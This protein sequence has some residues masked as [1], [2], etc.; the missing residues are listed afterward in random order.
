MAKDI[1]NEIIQK[2]KENFQKMKNLLKK[3]I[4]KYQEGQD[5]LYGVQKLSN[6]IRVRS[7]KAIALLRRDNIK[8]SQKVIKEAENLFKL[9]NKFTK[10]NEDL[11]NHHFYREATE[12]YVEALVY[13]NFLKKSKL[14]IPDFIEIKP[15]EI[16]SGICDFTGELL[17]KAITIAEKRNM[18]QLNLYKRTMEDVVEQLT[19]IGFRG[20]LRQ[21]YDE[22]ERNL[23]KIERILYEIKMKD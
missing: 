19:K 11:L 22:T 5:L 12:E 16:I 2:K 20:K 18:K 15:E 4:K 3:S 7:K 14:K 8:E 6:E 10:K 23:K 21:K 17:R 13:Y 9:I 1:L